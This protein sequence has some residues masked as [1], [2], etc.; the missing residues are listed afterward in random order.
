MKIQCE[1]S[2]TLKL[3]ALVEF[4]SFRLLSFDVLLLHYIAAQMVGKFELTLMLVLILQFDNRNFARVEFWWFESMNRLLFGVDETL[5]IHCEKY[6]QSRIQGDDVCWMDG[7]ECH[8]QCSFEILI[9]SMSGLVEYY[10]VK[11]PAINME[12]L[13]NQNTYIWC[14][15]NL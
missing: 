12:Q 10:L 2:W 14:K 7:R 11:L 4:V 6:V 5:C 13:I 9:E 15:L 1:W 3:F 8:L